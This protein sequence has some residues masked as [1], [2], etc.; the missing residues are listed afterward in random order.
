MQK[1]TPFL[2]FDDKAKE[3]VNFYASL[4]PDSKVGV[5]VRYGEAGAEVSGRLKGSVMTV[6]FR[7]AGE[8][9]MALNGGPP[10]AGGFKFTPA[11]SFSVTCETIEEVDML[12]EKLSDGGSVLMELGE[13]PWSKKYGWC[14][15]KY[16]L[17][18]Q[19]NL[20]PKTKAEKI[21][22]TFMFTQAVAGKAEEAM[23]FY[24]GLFPNSSIDFVAR[25]EEGE[26]TTDTPGTVKH[27]TFTLDGQG[28][29]ALDS[30]TK[31]HKFTFNEA[32][33]FMVNCKDQVEIDRYWDALSAV[34]ESE[35]CGWLKDKYGVSWQIV[36]AELSELLDDSDL[37]K[38]EKFMQAMLQMKKLD[39]AKLKA[40]RTL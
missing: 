5:A 9:F 15:D 21:R 7:L 24:A 38:S 32:V 33:S 34:P 29:I 3:A 26:S 6:A 28:F 8:D 35:Q 22:P 16:G 37:A 31:D 30:A 1:I 10:P 14:S 20:A 27:A 12:W 40:A 2:W 19:L 18:W 25:Y 23:Q 39:I 4:F 13:Y 17:S 36:P 11:V